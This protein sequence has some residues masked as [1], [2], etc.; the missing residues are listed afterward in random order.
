MQT[1]NDY[2]LVELILWLI[3]LNLL[4]TIKQHQKQRDEKCHWSNPLWLSHRWIDFLKHF[5]D[6]FHDFSYFLNFTQFFMRKS[7]VSEF[8]NATN[9]CFLCS[10][11][12]SVRQHSRGDN[13]HYRF[14]DSPLTI[15]LASKKNIDK[16]NSHLTF[17]LRIFYLK[18]LLNRNIFFVQRKTEAFPQF[19][20]NNNLLI[21]LCT[22]SA[23]F[24]A[25]N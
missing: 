10:F 19:T 2:R 11:S 22:D 1:G 8:F 15:I 20:Y 16:K 13:F 21:L 17:L 4:L 24:N 5:F 12:N 3:Q 23:P 18:C 9:Q 7:Q 25:L 14:A 6:L